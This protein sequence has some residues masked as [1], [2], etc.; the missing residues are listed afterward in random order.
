MADAG[1]RIGNYELIS[2]IGEGG[3]GRVFLAKHVKLARKVA[4]KLLKNELNH[5][6]EAVS[7]FFNEARAANMIGHEHIIDVTDFGTSPEGENYFVME[8]LSGESLGKRLKKEGQW[9]LERVLHVAI[10][11]ADALAAAHSNKIIHRD[12]KPDNVHLITRAGDPYY[13]KLLDFGIAKLL[14]DVD[15]DVANRTR[16]GI[17]MGTPG[18]MSPEQCM[19]RRDIDHR[20]DVYSFGVLLY[21]MVTGQLPFTS[22][23]WTEVLIA[24]VEQPFPLARKVRTDV[25]EK[26]DDVIQKCVKKRPEDR[27]QNMADVRDALTAYQSDFLSRQD[28]GGATIAIG[29]QQMLDAPLDHIPF[30]E[31]KGTTAEHRVNREMINAVTNVDHRVPD[32]GS[33]PTMG[34]TP[35]IIAP[36]A[37]DSWGTEALNDVG[38]QSHAYSAPNYGHIYGVRENA[39]EDRGNRNDRQAPSNRDRGHDRAERNDRQE[40]RSE[41]RNTGSSGKP[42]LIL[43]VRP[44]PSRAA[45]PA[46]APSNAQVIKTTEVMPPRPAE[47]GGGKGRVV[48][49]LLLLAVV[50][51]VLY[52]FLGRGPA[53]STAPSTP[54]PP[55]AAL[56]VLPGS[57]SSPPP[58]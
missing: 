46:P 20:A 7:R 3:M 13:V 48:V 28:P 45:E 44:L 32:D 31:P 53:H 47:E 23:N 29:H 42:P 12:L 37:R 55:A 25:E 51:G 15:A 2:V 18:H 17:M 49:I 52:W 14:D 39:E 1:A 6:A 10:Q 41:P 33:G 22:P 57:P 34:P 36:A 58:G 38:V 9:P 27:W 4:L 26:L 21:Q 35:S 16:S 24:H 56:A 54:P 50:A 30:E 8:W 19:G 40:S 43:E 11:L 5:R